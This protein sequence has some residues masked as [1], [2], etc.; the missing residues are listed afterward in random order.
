MRGKYLVLSA[1]AVVL[2]A[3]TLPAAADAVLLTVRATTGLTSEVQQF[4]IPCSGGATSWTFS[5]PTEIKD[6]D[7]VLGRILMLEIQT[8]VEPYVNLNFSLEA[9]PA[10][11]IFDLQSALVSF[12][13]LVNPQAFASA[14][15]TLTSDTDG[16]KITGLF[17]G[18]TY[19]ARYN[20][21]TVYADLVSG[22]TMGGNDSL[23]NSQRQ[24]ILAPTYATI[25]DTVSSIRSEFNFTLSALDQASGTSRF[26]VIQGVPE[27]ATL[28]LLA[29][30]G[31]AM[32]RR[33]KQS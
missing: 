29:L 26:E 17:G 24:P 14:G 22:F 6:G 15:I 20:G 21:T 4:T 30:G 5:T 31:L 23:L 2:L 1:V 16:A 8:D 3:A 25:S 11:T 12:S 9:G 10:D 13:P 27:P 19:Q 28:S 32:L 18:K 33:R 7:T